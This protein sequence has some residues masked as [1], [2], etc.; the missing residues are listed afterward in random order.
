MAETQ[1]PDGRNGTVAT[2]LSTEANPYTTSTASGQSHESTAVETEHRTELTTSIPTISTET[3]TNSVE[4]EVNT[5]AITTSIATAAEATTTSLPSHTLAVDNNH[6]T[7]A[8]TITAAATTAKTTTTKTTAKATAKATA[9]TTTATKSGETTAGETTAVETTAVP[10]TT[11]T[12]VTTDSKTQTGVPS[13]QSTLVGAEDIKT[14]KTTQIPATS[15]DDRQKR[16]VTDYLSSET[17]ANFRPTAVETDG[18]TTTAALTYSTITRGLYSQTR[19]E[20]NISTTAAKRTPIGT[21]TVRFA[22]G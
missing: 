20:N 7:A 21:S 1:L 2:S 8:A 3:T 17:T 14:A 4:D 5:T 22:S 15:T 13:P 9:K 6:T 18:N 12:T 16:T 10:T 11:N 19:D